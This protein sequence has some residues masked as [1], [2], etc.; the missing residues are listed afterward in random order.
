[1]ARLNQYV[2]QNINLVKTRVRNISNR[3][4]RTNSVRRWFNQVEFNTRRGI[5]YRWKQLLRYCHDDD[6]DRS[7]KQTRGLTFGA[8]DQIKIYTT[9]KRFVFYFSGVRIRGAVFSLATFR[10]DERT[11][12]TDAPRLSLI[13]IV[14]CGGRDCDDGDDDVRTT[15]TPFVR[16]TVVITRRPAAT[17]R[18]G[19]TS[20]CVCACAQSRKRLDA[21]RVTPGI[22]GGGVV[23]I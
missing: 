12:H 16:N 18:V 1:M 22:G 23:T 9:S 4:F 3:F 7:V 21:A 20:S 19:T 8:S 6:D 17:A 11:R 10:P 5:F 13:I 15:A 2:F 14:D